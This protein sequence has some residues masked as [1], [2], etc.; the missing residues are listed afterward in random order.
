MIEVLT[1]TGNDSQT[2]VVPILDDLNVE[3]TE[4][5]S[6]HLTTTQDG[7]VQLLI[8]STEVFIG[9][10]DSKGKMCCYS[11]TKSFKWLEVWPSP[12]YMSCCDVLQE[13]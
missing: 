9:D 12:L 5:F 8:D 4:S 13:L 10:N 6:A 2:V 11:V 1:F 3:S 7:L